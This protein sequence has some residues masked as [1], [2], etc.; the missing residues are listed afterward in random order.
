[1]ACD[2]WRAAYLN[3]VRRDRRF[4]E[5][6][7]RVAELLELR[8]QRWAEHLRNHLRPGAWERLLAA[9]KV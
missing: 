2:S 7:V 8:I 1:L 4:P 6:P 9:A 5:Q 3:Q